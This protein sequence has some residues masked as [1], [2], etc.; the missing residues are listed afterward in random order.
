MV[1]NLNNDGTLSNII[2]LYNF[3][4]AGSDTTIGAVQ[5]NFNNQL[6]LTPNTV[7]STFPA[8]LISFTIQSQTSSAIAF[9]D[10]S[11]TFDRMSYL[12][13]ITDF[14]AASSNL[15]NAQ[16]TSVILAD[17]NDVQ[18]TNVYSSS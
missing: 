11:I 14:N 9:A 5:A 15:S 1:F 2:G 13:T 16:P 18:Y 3:L 7:S 4:P 17:G 8:E 6:E 10:G 12:E